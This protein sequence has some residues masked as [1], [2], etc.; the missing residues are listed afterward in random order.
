MLL[1]PCLSFVAFFSCQPC[2]RLHNH[3][4][5]EVV[6]TNTCGQQPRNAAT[7]Y[8]SRSFNLLIF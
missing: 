7:T 8:N 1:S 2:L 6:V 4:A 3:Y 5:L